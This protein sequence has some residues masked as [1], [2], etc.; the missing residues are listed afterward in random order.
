MK[1]EKSLQNFGEFYKEWRNQFH[2]S[3][4]KLP[5]ESNLGDLDINFNKIED[6]STIIH[7]IT[8]I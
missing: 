5:H 2:Q 7:S 6:E 1:K 8:R 3:N 4:I